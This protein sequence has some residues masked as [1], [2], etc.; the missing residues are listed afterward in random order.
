MRKI[1]AVLVLKM[2]INK[3]QFSSIVLYSAFVVSV[4]F[5]FV[6]AGLSY[7]QIK[8]LS[9]AEKWVIHSHEIRAGLQELLL[10]IKRAETAQRDYLGTGEIDFLAPYHLSLTK[11]KKSFETLKELTKDNPEQQQKL[12]VLNKLISDRIAL[13]NIALKR[14]SEVAIT[15]SLRQIILTA[16]NTD[17][18]INKLSDVIVE[19]EQVLLRQREEIHDRENRLSPLTFLIISF[20][21]L[22]IFI[23]AFFK[24]RADINEMKKV[25]NQLLITNETFEHAEQIAGM[26]N[27]TWNIESNVLSY[28]ANQYRLLGC[29]PNEFEPTVESFTAFVHPE[30][31]QIITDAGT[32]VLTESVA[33]P[34]FFRVIRKDGE[35]R[36]FKSIG[37]IIEDN[38][39]KKILIGIN[40]DVT[41]QHLKDKE[42]EEKIF[43]LERSNSELSA[44]NHVASHDLQEPLR[45]IQT[46]ISRIAEKDSPTLSDKAKEYFQRTQVA[47]NRMQTLIN[48]LLQF[49]RANKAEKV[50]VPTDLN[51]LLENSLQE[52][53]IL[54][55]ETGVVLKFAILPTLNVIPFQIQQL[56]AN[57]IGNA[58]KYRKADVKPIIKIETKTVAGKE[59]NFPLA[60]ASKNYCL[61]T[62]SDNG[63]GFEHQYADTIFTLF[64]RL[65]HD[66]EYSGTGI[67]LTICKK[68]VENHKGF[69]S[70]QSAV[71]EGAAFSVYLPI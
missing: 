19:N 69:I 45:K 50:L 63:I 3:S 54:I 47:A 9:E 4:V 43:D 60:D 24:I 48:D 37:K 16:H 49:S 59:L 65:H 39:G 11:S 41:E 58:L 8:S 25:N 32:K 61:V 7:R 5:L 68:I 27:W 1:N 38:Y 26:S 42:L 51:L 13:L 15:D 52:L 17:A 34:A 2:K 56:F 18:A 31:R 14:Q 71:G 64:Q 36:Y 12:E 6:I 30:D 57:L 28:S 23:A 29:E 66:V 35:L 67:G 55:E 22:Q 70:A 33:T 46:L 20:F 44:F 10:N 40:L 62:V 21:S 53:G